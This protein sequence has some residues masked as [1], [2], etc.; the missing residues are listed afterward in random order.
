MALAYLRQQF[1]LI[2]YSYVDVLFFGLLSE[3]SREMHAI[4]NKVVNTDYLS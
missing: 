4:D 2:R 3:K 1:S